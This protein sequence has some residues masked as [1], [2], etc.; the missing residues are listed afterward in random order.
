MPPCCVTSLPI[1]VNRGATYRERFLIPYKDGFEVVNVKEVSH[2]Y[3][4]YKNTKLCLK[5]GTKYALNM[6]LD[7]IEQQLNPD[8]F[9]R[10]NR[11]FIVAIYRQCGWLEI[12]FRWKDPR[13]YPQL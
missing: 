11:Q 12:L 6:S 13:T 10:V 4:E 5:D 7:E 1:S 8:Q 9:F 2:I 3:S